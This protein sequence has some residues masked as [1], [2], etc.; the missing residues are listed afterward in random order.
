MKKVRSEWSSEEVDARHWAEARAAVLSLRLWVSG[1]G[2]DTRRECGQLS[3]AV[4]I[5]L[6]TFLKSNAGLSHLK[7]AGSIKV[8][9]RIDCG[10]NSSST[11][12]KLCIGHAISPLWGSVPSGQNCL[13][14]F[15]V[16]I[17]G[18]LQFSALISMKDWHFTFSQWWSLKSRLRWQHSSLIV[19]P[20]HGLQTAPLWPHTA[21]PLHLWTYECSYE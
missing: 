14:R 8:A 2:T 18:I 15:L 19:R 10:F 20:H 21:F 12:Y 4:E 9:M 1:L 16:G 17:Q 13:L 5:T 11:G 6:Y 3:V 7:G